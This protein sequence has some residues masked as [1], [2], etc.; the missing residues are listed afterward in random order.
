MPEQSVC[1]ETCHTSK[2]PLS[3][4]V[5]HQIHTPHKNADW[6]EARVCSVITG[7]R[8]LFNASRL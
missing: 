2:E 5:T 3:A 4:Q 6:V 8:C 7:Y 1:G